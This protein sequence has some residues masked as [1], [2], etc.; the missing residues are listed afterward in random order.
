MAAELGGTFM[1]NLPVICNRSIVIVKYIPD[2]VLQS[3]A[4][5]K[6]ELWSIFVNEKSLREELVDTYGNTRVL[7][8]K[9]DLQSVGK[10]TS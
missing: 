5:G 10:F 3:L 4:G 8:F 9:G 2:P 1:E 7:K 6:E